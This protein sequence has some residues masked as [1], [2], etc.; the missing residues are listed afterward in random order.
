[1]TQLQ[2]PSA[3][4]FEGNLAENWKIWEQK[5]DLFLIASE[6]SEKPEEVQCATFLHVAG[7]DAVKVYNTFEF[8]PAEANKLAVLKKKFKDYCEPRKNLPYIRHL[9]FTRAQGTTENID[10][11]VT[12]LKNKAKDCEFGDL[13]DSLIRDRIVCGVREDQ[14]RAR[15]LRETDLTLKRAID[16][17]RANE[18]TSNQ[19]KV[20]NEEIEVNKI[21]SVKHSKKAHRTKAKSSPTEHKTRIKMTENDQKA[22]SLCPRCGYEHGPKQCPAYGQTCKACNKKNH[23]AKKCRSNRNQASGTRT[24]H[25]V[26]TEEEDDFFIGTIELKKTKAKKKKIDTLATESQCKKATWTEKLKINGKDVS[27]KLDTGAECNVLAERSY[28]SL[29]T[30]SRL[31]VSSCKLLTYSGHQMS[32]VGKAT[33]TCEYKGRSHLIDFQI[34]DA[35]A[36]AILGRETCEE[37]GMVKRIHEIKAGNDLLKDF[38]DLFT[39]L[40]CLPGHHHIQ[41]DPEISPVIH[42]PRRVPIALKDKIVEELHRMEELGVIT[43]QHD[44]TDWVNSMV[45]I[46]KPN[47]IRICIDPQDL[48]RAIKREHYPLRTVEEVVA[49]MPKAKVFSVLDANHGFWKIKLDEESSKLCTFNTP[50][51]RYRFLR[52]PFGVSSAS[53]V[54]QHAI[55]QMIEGL[56]GV[57]NVI[58]DLLVWGETVEEHDRRLIQLLKRAREKNLKLNKSKCKIRTSEIRYI[59]HIL[60][61]DGLKPDPEKVRAVAQLPPP[62]SKQA[63]MRFMGMVQYLSKFIPNL[64]EVSAPLRKLLESDVEWHWEDKQIKS[65]EKMKTLLINAPTLTQIRDA[66]H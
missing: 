32:P 57:V 39:G 51:G 14:V 1:M 36:P 42:P 22:Q 55:A 8:A 9:F 17:C 34:I 25:V 12:D 19:V 59:G 13:H 44:P 54:F 31:K 2:P 50:I 66:C 37:L 45:T 48:N 30:N 21:R 26:E 64:S 58:D 11:Y 33:L 3:L 24:L 40:G 10:A 41:I 47:K 4:S 20:L 60:S 38:D 56:D 53:E 46:V 63:L 27:F 18:M 28:R 43:R 62:E 7:E 16:I 15:L 49:S 52:L 65:F 5:F 6:F 35:D 23:F 29:E 61:A